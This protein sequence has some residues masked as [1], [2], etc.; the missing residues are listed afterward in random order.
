M[1]E[2]S[3]VRLGVRYPLSATRTLLGMSANARIFIPSARAF[4]V[5]GQ[6][7][8]F[9]GGDLEIDGVSDPGTSRSGTLFALRAGAFF[10]F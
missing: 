1:V 3:L 6:F 7:S 4:D 10:F 5:S 2:D 8:W 9:S